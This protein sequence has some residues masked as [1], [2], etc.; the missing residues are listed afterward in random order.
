MT[1]IAQA[2]SAALLAFIWQGM[3]TA[4]LLWTAL[5]L[6]RDHSARARYAASCAALAAMA[7]LPVATACFLYPAPSAAR[8]YTAWAVVARQAGVAATQASGSPDWRAWF[9]RWALPAWALGVLLFSLRLAW[10]SRQVAALRRRARPAEAAVLAAVE[11]VRERMNVARPVRV[12]ISQAADCPAVVGWFQPAV[13]LPAAT[14]LGLTPRQLEAI[15]AHEFAH[16]LRYDYL[17]NM[18]QTAVETLLFYHPAVWW[19]SARI[20]QERELCCDDL[21]VASCGDAL[22]LARALTRLERLRLAPAGLTLSSNGSPLLYRIQRLTGVAAGKRGPSKLPGILVLCLGLVCMALN[23]QW[24]RGQQTATVG[25]DQ[26]A[27]GSESTDAPGVRVDL[28]GARVIHRD[29]V[30]YP[31][32]AIE[33]RVHG[34]V[35]VEATLDGEGEVNDARVISG[36]AEL[37]KAALGS[38]LQWHFTHD[39]AGGQLRVSIEFKLPPAGS[40]AASARALLSSQHARIV[41]DGAVQEEIAK[42]MAEAMARQAR[43]LQTQSS[44]D[45]E[46]QARELAE[47]GRKLAAE[48]D[49][50]AVELKDLLDSAQGR[51]QQQ[52]HEAQSEAAELLRKLSRDSAFADMPGSGLERLKKE[53]DEAQRN[54]QDAGF[55]GRVLKS[56]DFEGLSDAVRDELLAMLPVRAGDTLSEEAVSKVYAEVKRFDEHL[57]VSISNER[58]GQVHIRIATPGSSDLRLS[59]IRPDM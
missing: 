43:T 28:H 13:L 58:D 32:S 40:E 1:A 14:I 59:I 3:L 47:M 9:S 45:T 11:V 24:A 5:A 31:E 35:V 30:A 37:R 20:R 8:A 23:V 53:L 41:A 42:N 55:V 25:I 12:L 56:I 49:L 16:L 29:E 2:L 39:A 27:A 17:V 10:A 54:W 6:L 22:C 48:H 33:K 15:L 18:L 38:V 44:E 21:A 4:F 34:T 50:K 52:A 36:P 19:A 51:W 7:I 46:R 26:A 57:S